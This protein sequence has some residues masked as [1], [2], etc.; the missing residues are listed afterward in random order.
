MRIPCLSAG[1]IRQLGAISPLQGIKPNSN[2]GTHC[3]GPCRSG[4]ACPDGC[5]CQCTRVVDVDVENPDYSTFAVTLCRCIPQNTG[6][7]P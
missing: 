4:M 3:G 6:I 7:I 2:G 1:V 5:V